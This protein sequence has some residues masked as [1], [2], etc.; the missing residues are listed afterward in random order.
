MADL[1]TSDLFQKRI[2]IGLLRVLS[3]WRKDRRIDRLEQSYYVY[4]RAFADAGE[5]LTENLLTERIPSL[6]LDAA[7]KYIGL[8]HP[9]LRQRSRV[10]R[11]SFLR[12]VDNP[13][14]YERIPESELTESIG[15]YKV[16]AQFAIWFKHRL[17]YPIAR[18][19]A[20][21]ATLIRPNNEVG[22]D[23]T[24]GRANARAVFVEPFLRKK[25][26]SV[27][28]WANNSSVDFHTANDYLKGL[29]NPYRSTRKKLAE[30]LGLEPGQLP[31]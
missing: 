19:Q 20:K 15:G 4:A 5:L 17:E 13:S 8:P 29:T 12:N 18:W 9:S 7:V 16:T 1:S 31:S 23:L 25:G 2:R 11:A 22:A 24:N 6:V 26:W 30:S 28:E 3:E 14:H 10:V 27:F 21:A